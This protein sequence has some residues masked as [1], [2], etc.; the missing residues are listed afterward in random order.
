MRTSHSLLS[1]QMLLTGLLC[2]IAMTAARAQDLTDQVVRAGRSTSLTVPLYKSRVVE[3]PQ[4]VKRVSIGNPDI[5][6]VLILKSNELYILGKDLGST[7]VL[8]WD[9][10]DKLISAIAVAI[11]H[12]IDGLK[13]QLA[14]V[15]PNEKIEVGSAQRNIVLSGT[16]TSLLKMDAALRI[17]N[18]Y[19]EQAATAKEKIMFKPESG[20]STGADQGGE[21]KVGEVI[22]LLSVGGAQQVMLQVRVAEVR[23]DAVKSLNAQFNALNN[24]GKWVV[25]G[26]N[27]GATFPDAKF[28]PNDV[29]VPVFGNGTKSGGDP[30]GPVITEFHPNTPSI[31]GSGLFA[32]FLS[33]EFLANIVLDAAQQQ[34]LAKILAEPTVTTLTG[35]E[36]TFLSGGSFPIPVPQQNGAIGIEYKD[37][38]VKLVFQ[39]LILDNG[40]INLKLNISVSELVQANSLVVTP[41]TSSAVFAVPALSERRAG[42][43]VELA[44][45]QSIGIAGLMNE[46]MRDAVNRFP[47]LGNI[48]ILGALFRSQSYQ[49]GQTELVIL[50]TAKLAKPMK[51]AEVR[52]PTDSVV[53]PSNAEFFLGGRI[54]GSAASAPPATTSAVATPAGDAV[55][56][57]AGPPA[58]LAVGASGGNAA[59]PATPSS[60]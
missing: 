25:G 13:R 41:I 22:N 36:A 56:S 26:V 1:R 15:M 9:R 44:D 53:D 48:P 40:R 7:N 30:I 18:S 54:E 38:G 21:K 58:G 33:N 14:A 29:R 60:P 20:T 10:D 11:T 27:G 2:L 31:T 17:A 42:S 52:L 6:D 45:G 12:D 16:V 28:V 49:K 34:G 32:S 43:T 55:A 50:V 46:S 19:L 23:R 3:V 39:P 5:A 37:F 8:L 57:R 47:G 35:Q 4:P 59:A 24:N 51:P